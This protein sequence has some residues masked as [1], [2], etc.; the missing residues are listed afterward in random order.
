M[1][2]YIIKLNPYDPATID[3]FEKL[4]KCRKLAAF[5]NEA[6]KFFLQSE[7][8]TQVISL[9]IRKPTQNFVKTI[10][11]NPDVLKHSSNSAT[12]SSSGFIQ[13]G[14]RDVLENILK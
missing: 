2:K 8:G 4:R 3:V 14:Y 6:L 13:G 11:K 5:T 7:K 12:E 1:P 10:D 9:M